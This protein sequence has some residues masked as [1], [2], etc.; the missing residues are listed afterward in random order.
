MARTYFIT[1][2]AVNPLRALICEQLIHITRAGGGGCAFADFKIAHTFLGR[3]YV[4]SLFIPDIN[5]SNN[6]LPSE[7]IFLIRVINNQ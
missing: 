3:P 1:R 5:C 6:L 7:E 4:Y 2:G